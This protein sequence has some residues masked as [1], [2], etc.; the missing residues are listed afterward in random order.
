MPTD[1]FVC[2]VGLGYIGLPTAALLATSGYRVLGVD[3]TPAV[4]ETINRGDIHIVEP[5]LDAY[6][7]SAVQSG[8]LRA[9]TAPEAADVF[10]LCV[11]TPFVCGAGDPEPDLS[12]VLAAAESVAPLIRPGNMVIVAGFQAIEPMPMP[13]AAAPA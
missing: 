5:D 1:L 12:Y 11:P 4:A 3:V 13:P 6:V 7:R 2:V 10:L 9:A 8:R